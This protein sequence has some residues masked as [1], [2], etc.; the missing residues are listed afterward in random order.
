MNAKQINKSR[1]YGAI[2]TVLDNNL[3]LFQSI[4]ELASAHQQLKEKMVLIDQQRQVQEVK[5]TGLTKNKV[6]LREDLTTLI[7]RISVA[8]TALAAARNDAVLLA[9]VDYKITDLRRSSDQELCDIAVLLNGLAAP[10]AGGLQTYFVGPNELAKF[11]SLTTDFKAAMPL[12]RA[13]ASVTKVSTS[14]LDEVYHDIDALLKNKLDLLIQPF[15][16]T[17]PD[18]YNAYKNGRA[19]VNYTGRGKAVVAAS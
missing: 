2:T 13:A 19:I 10:E 9:K 6:I 3:G 14:N 15:R 1:M 8:L 18:F 11:D 4:P 7:L 17:Q 16:F 12:R 5:N